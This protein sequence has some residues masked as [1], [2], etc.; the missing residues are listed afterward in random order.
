MTQFGVAHQSNGQAGELS[1]SW[2]RVYAAAA[3]DHGEFGLT[4]RAHKR[5]RESNNDDN[6]DLVR[7]I[8]NAEVVA[9]WLPGLST[10]QLTWRTDLRTGRRGSLQLDWTYPVQASQP[11]GLRWYA[12]LFSGYGETLLDYN[13]RQTSLGVGLTL[14]QF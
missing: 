4:L 2:N 9:S 12:Q 5:L 3:F 10:A 14:F 8:G 1:R 13:H 7:Y 6:P 11:A